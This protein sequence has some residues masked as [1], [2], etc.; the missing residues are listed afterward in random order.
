MTHRK[1]AGFTLIELLVVISIIALLVALLLPALKA[2]REV[3]QGAACLSNQRQIGIATSVYAND[4]DAWLPPMMS[5][6]SGP[7]GQRRWPEILMRAKYVNQT[8]DPTGADLGRGVGVFACP[9]EEIEDLPWYRTHY[10]MN[11]FFSINW[12]SHPNFRQAR[13]TPFGFRNSTTFKR[14]HSPGLTAWMGDTYPPT[15]AGPEF[16]SIFVGLRHHDAANVLFFDMHAAAVR[17][18]AIIPDSTIHFW[19]GQE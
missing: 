17:G 11:Y 14:R 10:G 3:A 5:D 19:R 6:Q 8:F 7:G 18:D 4:F 13:L 1:P 15:S 16:L 12:P 9:S 2:A